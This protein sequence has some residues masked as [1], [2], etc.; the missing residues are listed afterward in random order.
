VSALSS[1]LDAQP[2]RERADAYDALAQSALRVF[3]VTAREVAFLGHNS[4]VAYRVESAR[5]GRLL[6][7]VH[8]PQGESEGLPVAAIRSGLGW[9]ATMEE[10]TDVAVQAPLTDL[11]GDRLPTV[12]FRG[13]SLPCSLQTWLDGEH[14]AELSADQAFAVGDLIGRWHT[15]SE[16]HAPTTDGAVRYDGPHLGRALDDLRVLSTTGAIT[17][18]SW[19]TIEAA[20][21]LVRD[22]IEGIGTSRAV[23]GVVHGDVNP[24]N[25]IVADNGTVGLID[26]AQLAFAPYLWDLGVAL[27]QYS[28]QDPSIR[29]ALVAGYRS[30]RPHLTIPPLSLEAFVCAAALDNLAFQVSIPTQRAS[31]LFHS[32]VQRFATGFCRDLVEGAP[33]A[34]E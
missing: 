6:L 9:L 33:F 23:F 8:A 29:R 10:T 34:L 7:K 24:D 11:S 4:G 22:L 25:V 32:N 27:Y 3:G 31:T 14:V 18:D 12:H 17:E 28:Y 13:V 26:L 19:H 2:E 21:G 20:T 30:A 1:L 15:A 5:S 16:Q